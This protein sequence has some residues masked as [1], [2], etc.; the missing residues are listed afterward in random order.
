MEG[1][2]RVER[3]EGGG[4][5]ERCHYKMARIFCMWCSDMC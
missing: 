4:L 5:G 3:G 2:G 1:V